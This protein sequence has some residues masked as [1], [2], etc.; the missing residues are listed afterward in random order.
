ML[1]RMMLKDCQETFVTA[2]GITEPVGIANRSN[3]DSMADGF[4]HIEVRLERV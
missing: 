2:D 3:S 1:A 4:F